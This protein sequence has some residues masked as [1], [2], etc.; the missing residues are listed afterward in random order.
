MTLQ[1]RA[2][3]VEQLACRV[4]QAQPRLALGAAR[5][6]PRGPGTG[7]TWMI[8]Q[9]L[10]LLA[11]R[12]GRRRDAGDG[13]RLVP[14]IV[15]VQRV[16][17]LL[18]ELGDD[19]T[20]LL[21]DPERHDALVH[22][23]RV[24][25]E[26]GR[27]T[28]LLLAYELRA[29]VILVDG[30]DEAAGMRDIVEAFV[31]YEL[32]PSGNRLVVTSR[33]EGVD[34]EDYKTRFV[35]MNLLELSQEQQRNVIQMQ[36][37]GN[38]FFEHLVNIAE[39]RKDLDEAYKEAFRTETLRTRWSTLRSRTVERQAADDSVKEADARG[40][41]PPPRERRRRADQARRQERRRPQAAGDGGVAAKQRPVVSRDG[42]A[43][44]AASQRSGG[45]AETRQL[46]LAHGAP[47]ASLD[48]HEDLQAWL[49]Q[50]HPDLQG[51]CSRAS[52]TR[53]TR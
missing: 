18:R 45:R 23:A 16:V 22:L 14:V 44:G 30:V 29:L 50:R 5:A 33:P 35:V 24:R 39:C 3:L 4:A 7:K 8:K 19:P 20:A 27:A 37:Q 10:F 1:R 42:A 47:P 25:R 41:G 46:E 15:F 28:M 13:V 11:E 9:T 43:K 31:H 17:R 38:S 32:V 53:S 49:E 12:L 34:M 52:S 48:N 6:L 51:G 36:L 21:P 2:R 40:Q 26:Q